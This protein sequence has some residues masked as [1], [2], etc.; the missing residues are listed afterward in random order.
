MF[1]WIIINDFRSFILLICFLLYT[2]KIFFSHKYILLYL[3]EIN[4]KIKDKGR[5][6]I[7]N[8]K[9]LARNSCVINKSKLQ[10]IFLRRE[11]LIPNKKISINLFIN[12]CNLYA[13]Y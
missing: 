1:I 4:Y 2:T 13:F 5:F 9:G 11:N 8:T 7:K 10:Y 12:S 3:V 6:N